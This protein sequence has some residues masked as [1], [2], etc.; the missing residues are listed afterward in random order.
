MRDY[1]GN[2]L[3]PRGAIGPPE[4]LDAGF[5]PGTT[6]RPSGSG[7]GRDTAIHALTVEPSAWQARVGK[8]SS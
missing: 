4:L 5:V 8:V 1:P 3:P 7:H 2:G 6:S